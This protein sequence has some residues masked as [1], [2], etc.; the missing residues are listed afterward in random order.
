MIRSCL[1]HFIDVKIGPE[2][3]SDGWSGCQEKG[4]SCLRHT[5]SSQKGW[6]QTQAAMLDGRVRRITLGKE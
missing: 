1:S 4:E 2:R 5:S 3:L 6:K